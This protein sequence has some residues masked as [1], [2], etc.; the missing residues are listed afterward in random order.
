M[1]SEAFFFGPVI[2]H[3]AAKEGRKAGRTVHPAMEGL[4]D[5]RLLDIMSFPVAVPLWLAYNG[6]PF[7]PRSIATSRVIEIVEIVEPLVQV[8][9]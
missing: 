8:A 5:K 9:G 2:Q 3:R 6:M 7:E 4:R 1:G